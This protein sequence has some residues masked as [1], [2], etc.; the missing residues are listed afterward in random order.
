MTRVLLVSPSSKPGGAERAFCALAA[1]LPSVGYDPVCALL[2]EGPLEEWLEEAGCETVLIA[3]GRLRQPTRVARTIARLRTLARRVEAAAVVSN[4][5]KGHLYGGPTARLAGL[6]AIWWLHGVPPGSRVERFAGR[7]PAAA[8][9]CVSRAALH[10]QRR[11]TPGVPLA[12]VP[13]GVGL[14]RA[15]EARG[16]GGH[17]RRRLGWNAH[18]VVG[19]VGRLQA[20]KGQAVFLRAAARLAPRLPEVQFAV[21]GGA[22]LGWE[23]SYPDDLRRLA[24]ELGIVKRVHFAGHQPDPWPWIDALDVMVS[25]STAAEGFPLTL[26]EAMALQKPVVATDTGGSAEMVEDGVSGLLVPPGDD[27]A[28]AEAIGRLLTERST[29][30]RLAAAGAARVRAFGE[31]ATAERFA[32]LLDEVTGAEGRQR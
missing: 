15:A 32:E 10:A 30:E 24:D 19:I 25:A 23:G 26:L 29:A 27:S 8:I 6:P 20:G 28:L 11:L 12:V 3:A 31:Q 9:A 4:M 21:V 5:V 13:P 22:V 14:E 16:S 1:R 18:P 7:V 2:Q 17:V